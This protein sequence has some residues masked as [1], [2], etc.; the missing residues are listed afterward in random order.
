[1][2]SASGFPRDRLR[3]LGQL[4]RWHFWFLGRRALVERL[5]GRRLAQP[6]QRVLDLGCGTGFMLGI[7][8]HPGRRLIGIDLRTEGLAATRRAQPRAW[9]AQ[10]HAATLPLAA[11]SVHVVLLLDVLEHVDD[12]ALLLEVAR[13]LRPGGHLL[14]TVPALPWLWSYRDEAAGHLRR[15]TRRRLSRVLTATCWQVQEMRYYQCLL[16]PVA[17]ATRLLGRGGPGARDL[18]ER[19]PRLLNALLTSVSMAEAALG[20]V[21]AWPWGLSLVALCQKA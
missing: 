6:G 5:L 18:E 1:M 20:D 4:E 12:R 7:L 19:P 16:L 3:R 14:L 13:V 10:A 15:Y 11:D 9:V 21:V 8:S 2:R 17:I